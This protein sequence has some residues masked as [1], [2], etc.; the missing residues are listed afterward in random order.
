MDPRYCAQLPTSF[1][2][3]DLDLS[4]ID[5]VEE[6]VWKVKPYAAWKRDAIKEVVKTRTWK[7]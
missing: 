5:I 2:D 1:G 6:S 4:Y 7:G 3:T